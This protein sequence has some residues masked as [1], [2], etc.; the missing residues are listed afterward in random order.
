MKRWRLLNN[1]TMGLNA[2]Y[3]HVIVGDVDELV[4]VDP[5]DGRTLLQWLAD[6]R[7]RRVFT[8]LGLEILHRID[9]E[10]DPISDQVIG[11]R[12][13]VRVSMEYSKPCIVSTGTRIARGGHFSEFD[14]LFTPP[15]LYLFHLKYADFGTYCALMDRRN[16]VTEA[17][18]VDRPRDAAIGRHWFAQAR[19]EDRAVF[20]AFAKRPL[21]P[22]FDMRPFRKTMQRSWRPRGETGFWEFTREEDE[23]Q[24]ILPERFVGA[25]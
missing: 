13:H 19:G 22:G 17:V 16:A 23:G 10:D 15:E 14:K 5:E 8:P 20:E 21:R 11:P 3:G 18:G 25:I 4:V 24:Y 1:I 7:Q 6:A 9:V 2:Y 12:R